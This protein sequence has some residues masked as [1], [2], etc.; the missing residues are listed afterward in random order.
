M[1]AHQFSLTICRDFGLF[2]PILCS[3]MRSSL[4]LALTACMALRP[5]G[6]DALL[7][8][9]LLIAPSMRCSNSASLKSASTHHA[10]Q[11]RF[12]AEDVELSCHA[13]D[14]SLR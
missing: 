5:L 14:G 4:W 6:C 1:F 2:L 3:F 13:R 11:L 10:P 9:L 7:A 8:S 12:A